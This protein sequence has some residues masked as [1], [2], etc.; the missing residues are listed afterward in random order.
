MD[1]GC[2]HRGKECASKV[3]DPLETT[4][5]STREPDN[6]DETVMA[7]ICAASNGIAPQEQ[8]SARCAPLHG[9]DWPAFASLS[10]PRTRTGILLG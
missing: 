5:R 6:T 2:Y 9:G 7:A 4:I 1:C 8:G 3:C 10:F